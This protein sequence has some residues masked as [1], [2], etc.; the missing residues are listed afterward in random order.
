MI[1]LIHDPNQPQAVISTA[2]VQI[3][4][5]LT[6]ESPDERRIVTAVTKGYRAL[7]DVMQSTAQ[8]GAA[9]RRNGNASARRKPEIE[10]TQNEG[11]P[12][13][14]VCTKQIPESRRSDAIYCSTRCKDTA[15]KRRQRARK[16]QKPT[17]GTLAYSPER[18]AL[19]T[20]TVIGGGK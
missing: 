12:M 2:G 4:M 17:R 8:T 13:C 5:Q 3:T 10:G 19:Q 18:N 16:K 20:I 11:R 9:T 7:V 6:G 14:D 15:K 1:R